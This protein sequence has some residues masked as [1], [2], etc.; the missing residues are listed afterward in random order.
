[1]AEDPYGRI[2]S[3]VEL[4]DG[5]ALILVAGPEFRA[6]EGLALIRKR[7]P[8]NMPTLWHRLDIDGPDFVSAVQRSGE[9]RAVVLVHGL[10]FLGKGARDRVMAG[11]NLSRDRLPSLDA[12]VV[13]WIPSDD[14]ESF[15]HHCADLFAWRSLLV[16]LNEEHVPTPRESED[17]RRYLAMLLRDVAVEEGGDRDDPLDPSLLGEAL[18]LPEGST[19][20]VPLG[21]WARENPFAWLVAEPGSG[22]TTALRDLVRRWAR[23]ATLS[24]PRAPV[25]VA[26]WSWLE[27][28]PVFGERHKL[29]FLG[30]FD[31]IA[32]AEQLS[33]PFK[34]LSQWARQEK[35]AWILDEAPSTPDAV[36]W[37]ELFLRN[38]PAHRVLLAS[39]RSPEML[40]EPWRRASL[41]MLFPRQI[42]EHLYA[43]AE[44]L[45]PRDILDAALDD[46]EHLPDEDGRISPVLA[47]LLYNVAK[48]H[49]GRALSLISL[50]DLSVAHIL[51]ELERSSSIWSKHTRSAR[52]FLRLMAYMVFDAGLTEF[53]ATQVVDALAYTRVEL[54]EGRTDE[55]VVELLNS[56]TARGWLLVKSGPERFRFTHRLIQKYLVAEFLADESPKFAAIRF[57]G[58]HIELEWVTVMGIVA[59]LLGLRGGDDKAHRFLDWILTPT[60]RP[61]V[62][63]FVLTPVLQSARLARLAPELTAAWREEARRICAGSP[64]KGEEQDVR[65]RLRTALD[66]LE[67]LYAS[68]G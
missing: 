34:R 63:P 41:P 30:E 43:R 40:G 36:A 59:C 20:F 44:G 4:S 53:D 60:R 32:H 16:A 8:E 62:S 56:A 21:A 9:R 10:E 5:L 31:S 66:N 24:P 52:E 2:A 23:E 33:I 55:V 46:L 38:F 49:S 45:G 28:V 51:G 50:L 11:V 27:G 19:S 26:V 29:R 58:V 25:P 3:T 12:A 54:P 47:G 14:I 65:Q 37:A 22:K 57:R 67:R 1:M 13:L 39:R 7:L 35:L 17:E 61:P 42:R 15:Q 48:R 6:P 64:T 68:T 18:V